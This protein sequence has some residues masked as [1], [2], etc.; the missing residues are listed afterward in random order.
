M[1][2]A[3]AAQIPPIQA[4]MARGACLF[5]DGKILH[6]G[7]ANRSDSDRQGVNLTYSVGWVRQE[8][9]QYLACPAEIA[10]SLDDVGPNRFSFP[11]EHS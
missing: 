10:R 2:D 7:G 9:N 8:E 11:Q 3:E 6:G 1:D 5:Y 4:E